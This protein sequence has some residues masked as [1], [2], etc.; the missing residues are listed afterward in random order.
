MSTKEVGTNKM[1]TGELI[2]DPTGELIMALTG[3]MMAKI[4]ELI[5]ALTGV[6]MAQTGVMMAQTGVMMAQ[7]GVMMAKIGEMMA[8]TGE[9]MAPTGVMIMAKTGVMIMAKTGAMMDQIG[10]ITAKIGVM[11]MALTGVMIMALTGVMIMAPIG[12]KMVRIGTMMV[13]GKIGV[14]LV[15][16]GMILGSKKNIDLVISWMSSQGNGLSYNLSLLM[17]MIYG[18]GVKN[19]GFTFILITEVDRLIA[20]L[21]TILMFGIVLGMLEASMKTGSERENNKDGF[22]LDLVKISK[23]GVL[24]ITTMIMELMMDLITVDTT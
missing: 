21:K 2:M 7:T 18:F 10:V 6:M 5:M 20:I 17:V 22:I 16:S 13:H 3:V 8:P 4:G 14:I 19:G 11:I 24:K 1:E 15:N 12:E 23:I 9:M